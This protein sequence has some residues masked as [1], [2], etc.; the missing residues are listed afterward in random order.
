M[1]A[2][3]LGLGLGFD[4]MISLGSSISATSLERAEEFCSA[5]LSSELST[6]LGLVTFVGLEWKDRV[7]CALRAEWAVFRR[8]GILSDKTISVFQL[9][10]V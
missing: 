10:P 1:V 3:S 5:F 9:R 8:G 4:L 2:S 7:G 6:K